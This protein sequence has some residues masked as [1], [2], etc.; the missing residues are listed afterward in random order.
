MPRATIDGMAIT[1]GQFVAGAQYELDAVVCI[2][3]S[4]ER[5]SPFAADNFPMM[6]MVRIPN[7]RAAG[8]DAPDGFIYLR[9]NWHGVEYFNRHE[10]KYLYDMSQPVWLV[11]RPPPAMRHTPRALRP[12]APTV[13][14]GHSGEDGPT[15]P[16]PHRPS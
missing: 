3:T 5:H 11:R 12:A 9:F 14:L 4:P 1:Y 16:T 6:Y 8:P 10:A 2:F 13:P 7:P 15:T